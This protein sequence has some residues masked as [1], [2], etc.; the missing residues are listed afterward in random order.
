LSARIQSFRFAIRGIALTLRSQH[1]AWIHA[2]A[3]LGV[4]C[5]GL[6]MGVSR[7]EWLALILAIVVVWVAEGLNTAFEALCDVTSPGFH[8]QVERAK[9][10]AAGAVLIAALGG[11]VVGLLVFGPRLV[12]MVGGVPA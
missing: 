11:S 10:I 6:W 9:D 5:L 4:V 2:V 8:P 12:S 3:T 1:N 7:G